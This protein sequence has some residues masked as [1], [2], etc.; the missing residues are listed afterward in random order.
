MSA[1]SSS[2]DPDEQFVLLMTRHQASLTAFVRSLVPDRGMAEEVLQA[3]TVVLWQ[4][5]S[6]FAIGSNFRAWAFRVARFQAMAHAKTQQRNRLLCFEEGVVEKLSESALPVLEQSDE[7]IEA[8]E[9]CLEKLPDQD[10][11]LVE[12]CYFEELSMQQQAKRAG[13]S[14]GALRQVLYRIRTA[15]RRCVE[16]ALSSAEK[17]LSGEEVSGT[18]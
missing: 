12:D 14:V 10:R 8:L 13:R 1:A 16:Q 18:V 15:L 9:S 5:R 4:K 7:R 3:S 11:E 17:D 2:T 6:D